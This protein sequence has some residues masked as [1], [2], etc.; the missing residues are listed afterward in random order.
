MLTDAIVRWTARLFVACYVGRVGI[1]AAGRRD[2]AAQRA[3]RWLWTIGC[4]VFLIHIA[5][6]FHLVHG[7][8]HAAAH[9]HVLN[10][11]RDS[12]GLVSGMGLYVNYGF[13]LLW[14]ADT[15]LW[16]RNLN[17]VERPIPFR[18]VQGIFA[19]L[20]LQSTAVFGPSLWT[21]VVAVVLILLIALR[22]SGRPRQ[23]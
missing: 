13:A 5:A 4:V 17:W 12:T 21:P 1:D 23:T 22:R 20:M 18:I 7:W 3:A 8:S 19:F 2:A 10:R 14:V 15:I 11:T 9:E 16:W 6:A